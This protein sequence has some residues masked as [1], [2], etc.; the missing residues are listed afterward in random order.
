MDLVEK[1]RPMDENEIA[2]TEAR[3]T[4]ISER[5][6]G[7]GLASTVK[8]D[9]EAQIER[10][11]KTRE[12]D[13]EAYRL[14]SYS[15]E[16]ITARYR[17]GKDLMS[18]EDLVEYF[19][20]SH[21]R[22]VKDADFSVELPSEDLVN[23]GEE[24]KPLKPTLF[25]EERVTVKERLAML[26]QTVRSLPAKTVEKIR[27]SKNDWFDGRAA[28]TRGE[29]R[30]FP[31]S[32]FAAIL[33]VAMSLMLVVASSV[34][35]YHGESRLNTLKIEASDLSDE[36]FEMKNDLGAKTDLLAIRDVAVNE[37]GMVSEAY[38]RQEYLASD[39]EDSIVVYEDEGEQMIGLGALLNALG[40]K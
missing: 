21:E 16:Y 22:H 40:I 18:G 14:S 11:E 3:S 25:T 37:F 19:R 30:R 2:C 7:R 13:P 5:F 12:S 24:D 4:E 17:H 20:E 31:L 9:A 27:L 36:I 32:A 1:N 23:L 35:I 8:R 38:V 39:A 15:E 28:D 33:A 6:S 26:P 10:E 29:T 34:M